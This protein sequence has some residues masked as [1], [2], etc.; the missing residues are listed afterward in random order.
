VIPSN[1]PNTDEPGAT[2]VTDVTG[3]TGTIVAVFD[4]VQPANRQSSDP[5]KQSHTFI[6]FRV[7]FGFISISPLSSLISKLFKLFCAWVYCD[8]WPK[9]KLQI[10]LI[11]RQS[12]NMYTVHPETVPDSI[13]R[14]L[15][16]IL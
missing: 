3:A 13:L 4:G 16:N 5:I 2:G 12:V 8:R 7:L 11:M 15:G 14:A 1:T 9:F 6:G 10:Y